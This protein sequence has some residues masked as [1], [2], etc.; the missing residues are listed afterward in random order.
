MV[1]RLR[2][3]AISIVLM[4]T[5]VFTL[6]PTAAINA[7][8]A[9]D[10]TEF[11][12]LME[13]QE[14]ETVPES[15][16]GFIVEENE[17]ITDPEES[18]TEDFSED[19]FD[20]DIEAVEDFTD[21]DLT[22]EE[23]PEEEIIED[24]SMFLGLEQEMSLMSDD[25]PYKDIKNTTTDITFGGE[26]WYL[27]DYDDNTVTLLA[28]ECVASSKYNESG[29][30]VE[31]SN[32]PTV[33]TAVDNW[34]SDNITADAKAAVSG[35]A[36]F[37]LT[38]A[39]ASTIYSANPNVLKCSQA[40]GGGWWLCSQGSYNQKAAFVD[41]WS[42]AVNEYGSLVSD[43]LGVRPALQLD[44]S[45]VTFD[46]ESKTFSLPEPVVEYPLWVGGVRVTSVNVSDV[47]ASDETNKGKVSFT[48]ATTGE[49]PTPATLTLSNA[50]I[51]E[52]YN[53]SDHYYG[54]YYTGTDSFEIVLESD[55]DNTI[56]VNKAETGKR[57]YGIYCSKE[58]TIS[59]SGK[60]TIN[61]AGESDLGIYATDIRIDGSELDVTGGSSG[62]RATGNISIEGAKVT[63]NGGVA[64]GCNEGAYIYI[65]NASVVD[66]TGNYNAIN[67]SVKNAIPGIGWTNAAGTQGKTVIE[68]S[69]TGQDLYSYK[70]L[71]FIPEEEDTEF[72]KISVLS[73]TEGVSGKGCR[74]LFDKDKTTK[75]C[76]E[77]NDS[78]YVIF[79][80][81][82]SFVMNSYM[83]TTADDTK[84][85]P[86]RNWK[87]WVIYGGSFSNDDEALDDNA[88]WTSIQSI[89][90]DTVLKAR[91][92]VDY[93]FDV[94]GNETAYKYYKL[95]ITCSDVK[96]Q[97]MAEMTFNP[98]EDTVEG[99]T[100]YDFDEGEDTAVGERAVKLFDGDKTN[101]WCSIKHDGGR[102]SNRDKDWVIFGTGT[103]FVL[104][105]Y[106]L[107][108]GNDTYS[109]P[110]RN[111][112]DW[113]IFG[114]NDPEAKYAYVRFENYDHS[115]IID[116]DKW[117]L[118]QEIKNDTVLKA[119]NNADYL[120][121][122]P[123]NTKHYKYYLL[124][125]DAI[126]SSSDNI[127]QMAEM[128][129]TVPPVVEYPLWVGDTRVTSYNASDVFNDGTVSFAP[130]VEDDTTTEEDESAPATLKLNGANIT[131]Y[132]ELD[133]EEKFGIYY[134]DTDDLNIVLESDSEN[135]V[136]EQDIDYGFY[137]KGN[138]IISGNGSLE[139]TGSFS[140]IRCEGSISI[141][142]NV[143]LMA[144][145]T[146]IGAGTGITANG[147][148]I[149]G[150]M[151]VAEGKSRGIVCDDGTVSILGG[152][153]T[154]VANS[155][156]NDPVPMAIDGNVVNSIPGTGWTDAAGIE[157]KTTIETSDTGRSLSNF[158]KLE[159]QENYEST[160][161]ETITVLTGTEG[162]TDKDCSKLFNKDKTTTW[163]TTNKES[164]YVIFKAD[165]PFIMKSYMLTTGPDT[166][167]YPDR[168]WKG[169]VIYGGRF[170]SDKAA[171]KE[172]ANWT[173][174]KSVE[175]DTL[176]KARNSVDYCFD[177]E[178][179]EIAYKYYKLVIT[180]QDNK[181]QEMA[182]MTINPV[183]DT[184]EGIT[185]Y[186]YDEGLSTIA[187]ERVVKLF[188]GIKTN[189]WCSKTNNAGSYSNRDKDWV[190][191]GADTAFV[192][193]SYV[194]TTGNDTATN[195][196]RNWKDWRIFGSNDPDSRY[197]YVRFENEDHT[198][199]IDTEKWTLIQEIK[200]DTV[201]QA[202][203]NTD[204]TFTIPDNTKHYKYY[205]L[206]I[207]AIKSS[208]DNIQQ[209]AEMTINVPPVVEYPLWVGD[210]QVTNYN[211]RDIFNDGTVSFAPA[212][213]GDNPT[214]ATLTLSGATITEGYNDN[215][216]YYG[217]Y[218]NGNDPFEI[219]LESDTQ[220]LIKVNK[221]ESSGHNI[222]I[223]CG[224]VT[225]SGEGK[226]TISETG[227]S[228]I[229]IHTASYIKISGGELD[230]TAGNTGIGAGGNISI[231]G[232]KVTANGGFLAIIGNGGIYIGNDSEVEATG[233]DCAIQNA[234]NA[235]PGTG[236]TNTAGTEGE[237]TIWVS[238][239]GQSLSGYKKVHFKALD[240]ISYMAWDEVSKTLV[241]MNDDDA[242]TSYFLV[243]SANY[244][245]LDYEGV[246]IGS[247][248]IYPGEQA[249][250]GIF[251]WVVIDGEVSFENRIIVRGTAN[252]IIKDGA[253]L[254]AGKG[255]TVADGDTLNI[256]S[257]ENCTGTILA[258]GTEDSYA[259][260][261][262]TYNVS[263]GTINIHGGNITANGGSYG[264]GIGGGEAANCGTVV[265][266]GGTVTAT[267]GGSYAK[268]IGPSFY[269][270][271][272]D[273]IVATTHI[274]YSNNSAIT[275]ANKSSA[276]AIA[277][278]TGAALDIERN[279]FMLV[280]EGTLHTHDFT[281]SVNGATI[282]ATCTEGCPDGYDSANKP[283]LTIVAP[284]R[285]VYNGTGSADATINGSI[286]DVTTPGIVYSKGETTLDAAP[287]DAGTYT[288]SITV[289]EKTAS[290]EYSIAK[291]DPTCTAPTDLTATYGQTLAD[292]TLT[293]P[294]GNTE[295]TWAWADATTT[296]VGNAGENKFKVNF[297]P[298]DN[299]NY[300][301]KTDVEV[302]IT[303]GKADPIA[304]A[305]LGFT[306]TY[307]QTLADIT[308]TNP[309]GNTDG[310]W[311]WKDATTTS[312]GNVGEQTFKANFTPTDT[313]NYN[314]RTDVDV[315]ITVK[316][317]PTALAPTG[318]TAVYGQT[319]A[320]V[321]LTNPSG[322]T[323]GTWAWA[324]ATTTSVGNAG[325]NKF[326]INFTP[327][328]TAN[329]NGKTDIEVTITVGKAD[330]TAE[331]PTGLK[332]T[333]GQTLADVTLTNP[334]GNTEGTWAWADATTTSVGNAG[335]NKFKA[336]F[337]P[338]DTTNYNVK[339]DV[340]LTINVDKAV[341]PATVND[342]ATVVAGGLTVDL[343]DNVSFNGAE[344]TVSYVIS[345]DDK[346]MGCSISGSVLTSG[347]SS[348]TVTV[349][350]SV[351]ED[352]NY[353]ALDATPI[354]VTIYEPGTVTKAP[355]AKDIAYTGEPQ[356][357]VTAG[358]VAGEKTLLYYALGEKDKAP[359]DEW[360]TSIPEATNAGEYYV[361]YKAV[362]E[363][364]G[365]NPGSE[366]DPETVTVVIAKMDPPVL[367]PEKGEIPKA[368]DGL[369][370]TGYEQNLV[371]GPTAVLPEGYTQMLYA[372]G[373]NGTEAP[374]PVSFKATVA[375]ATEPGRY[376]VW[377]M[378]KGDD[379]HEDTA[380][381]CI[382][383]SII[384]ATLG[385]IYVSA[386][387][388]TSGT[389]EGVV[390]LKDY[391]PEDF[392]CIGA[393]ALMVEDEGVLRDYI[394]DVYADIDGFVY[395]KVKLPNEKDAI[396]AGTSGKV[397][398]T[399]VSDNYDDLLIHLTLTAKDK[400]VSEDMVVMGV[401]DHVYYTGKAIKM[402]NLAV[403]SGG[404]KLTSKDYS[405]SYK[406]NKNVGTAT[407]TVKGK[408]NYKDTVVD[409]FEILPLDIG[410]DQEEA[411]AAAY[412]EQT[413]YFSA[414]DFYLKSN[415]KNQKKSPKL[416]WNG[417]TVAKSNYT[418]KYYPE[419]TTAEVYEGY[420]EEERAKYEKTDL[421]NGLKTSYVM[422]LEGKAL[423][424]A[425]K[426]GN[427]TGV[428]A[429]N[430]TI[431]DD[432]TVLM[433]KTKVTLDKKEYVFVTDN[434]DG[435]VQPK[436]T[437]KYGKNGYK[438][439]E[440]FEVNYLN[441]ECAGTGTIVI[442][443]KPRKTEIGLEGLSGV[444]KINFK[445]KA[446]SIS[447]FT[448]SGY[449]TEVTFD[450][451]QKGGM[452]ADG[453]DFKVKD[454]TTPLV[455]GEDYTVNYKNN[456]KAG[457]ATMVVKGT[458]NYTGTR[459]FK[460]KI[461]K[462]ALAKNA[463]VIC[464]ET[465]GYSKAGAKAGVIV[466]ANGVVLKEKTDYTLSYSGNK[467]V[468]DTATVKITGKGNYTGSVTR[469]FQVVQQ[470]VDDY[471]EIVFA[472]V[473]DIY[474]AADSKSKVASYLKMPAVKETGT[475][476]TLK[477]GTDFDAN[478]KYE[479]LAED[480]SISE[481]EETD[482]KQSFA[483][484]IAKLEKSQLIDYA[485]NGLDIRATVT[486]KGNYS[487]EV[488]TIYHIADNKL[489]SAKY[490]PIQKTYT[491]YPI[492]LT[493]DFD[494]DDNEQPDLIVYTGKNQQE[495]TR[496]VY[497][498][499]YVIVDGSY[500]KNVKTGT[501]QVTIRG[502]GKF[503]GNK[504]IKF[505]IVKKK[506]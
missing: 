506:L 139:V 337:T 491:G 35:G 195:S 440:D 384:K 464:D 262:G 234:I 5:M 374:S 330:P 218:Y 30:F 34:Y 270:T 481:I 201:L 6:F 266:Y 390:N 10:N 136:S 460:F 250:S 67:G 503:E 16:E 466:K 81:D 395:Y 227:E 318:L 187:D 448:V 47:L 112:N 485:Q 46:S 314:D 278:G 53:S 15:E 276:K 382:E 360:S 361:W 92:S 462:F 222:G 484:Y 80:A 320:D 348:G 356:V 343:K 189:K 470:E 26:L 238:E 217:I 277:Q 88:E 342:T 471:G 71:Q 328:D 226:L 108:T 371:T 308:L 414:D 396:P 381:V 306:A 25:S 319:L 297:T 163:Y 247:G 288:A 102:Y 111:W 375:A 370:Y 151:F 206:I 430:V 135:S 315:T 310:T 480:Y 109:N 186:D 94:E 345:D 268:G 442:T 290:V 56:E 285:T 86:D 87:G 398:V 165:N 336:N 450:P 40:S 258:T 236:W 265:I 11:G 235:I 8:A 156:G 289:G 124:I 188:D 192:L 61:E 239:T 486:L 97:Q 280:E 194:L 116:T 244:S 383:V 51:S 18:E 426:T 405:V 78:V 240:P 213:T 458:G 229:G 96:K 302:T 200:N 39:Q 447:K 456:T 423:D 497:G 198:G 365:E 455:R 49:N 12:L 32:N 449:K 493:T 394:D 215:N 478:V 350:V 38:T 59:G 304:V 327:E 212:T 501:A 359:V 145:G 488:T 133:E 341:S 232:A 407:I 399:F 482:K 252:V 144:T 73:G 224:G 296:S 117:T 473:K 45:K 13:Q 3:R 65:D 379:N 9:E 123:D 400:M 76:T 129:I 179:N 79:K 428:R 444:R 335:E 148:T 321:T 354:M 27:I 168:N 279:Q 261:G 114:S 429:V 172:D 260:I 21:E 298:T 176:L 292:V 389:V 177:V 468:G 487:G 158:R 246:C 388:A 57:N 459:N 377:Y 326:K 499:D 203:N 391:I 255:I 479:V 385:E 264:A 146:R 403:Y 445:I 14:D 467:K 283:T 424:P 417:K 263:S 29:S 141:S 504:V 267:G 363:A 197:A 1:K 82:N 20:D 33:K 439:D 492:E 411:E 434:V 505:K 41:G 404:I 178:D 366:K 316:A 196:G 83:L 305:P 393:E 55:T 249:A 155:T 225:I 420:N 475:G 69:K 37:L 496:L 494:V 159:F 368:V 22:D 248:A 185:V 99:I 401:E 207:D 157:G 84:D 122:I 237:T 104:D 242:C 233:S 183:E 152:D 208:N 256:Y 369:I 293:N 64:I 413:D 402:P 70:K 44:L 446:K 457:T 154:V 463:Q 301:G 325:E 89:P 153:V 372:F 253:K 477:K 166:K 410:V 291:A 312:V 216:N 221:A 273:L 193:D 295:G 373:E 173:Q 24:S 344:G 334:S 300:N 432:N 77:N 333:Y 303:V 231:E 209:M 332:A 419:G 7:Y 461:S 431:Y 142:E 180:C 106:V 161:F 281:Y 433:S 101:K 140:G 119:E 103:S 98:V 351:T 149:N 143:S 346:D 274:V 90:N 171:L 58:V 95:V 100:V 454:G 243:N 376:F 43:T 412:G 54:I 23:S 418:V 130:A 138:L 62:I 204:Y 443:G 502:L 202:A 378:A 121:T 125:I 113:R 441:N 294:S 42:G 190:I 275:D 68:M 436:V 309:L 50:N 347:D 435:E 322:N 181:A 438:E 307:G 437:V 160:T 425:A 498:E 338:A 421:K 205:L 105:S 211:A 257:Q 126:E 110:G 286:P 251:T 131:T 220:N 228:D 210:T 495:G 282:T 349:Y 85:Y 271:N 91:N 17:E 230:I 241:E 489:S 150:G 422:I 364:E 254:T 52:G 167:T 353:K 60:L 339:S 415:G 191:F 259:G 118:I 223:I 465:A 134:S 329:Y 169:W 4:L 214:P 182:E 469:T 340:E 352:S 358:E 452:T 362:V 367:D 127:Q 219:V 147:V 48:P 128:T 72:G 28:E 74:K 184:G 199:I 474:A 120:F 162:A 174:I 331:A 299:A 483:E 164:A 284:A 31:Y 317:D 472:T 175:E 380:P 427:F 137:S 355:E 392:E 357:L 36:M 66:A 19:L 287:T 490:V 451:T 107:T 416:L 386:D 408:G 132:C 313:A 406:N 500:K 409:T 453:D 93:Y 115:G 170:S 397:N 476:K 63:A 311:A 323:E 387:I 75:W 324:D 272:G 2:K 245:A 269:G